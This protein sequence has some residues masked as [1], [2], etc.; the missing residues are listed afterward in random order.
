MLPQECI[1]NR[2]NVAAP[3][4]RSV[5]SQGSPSLELSWWHIFGEDTRQ[6]G[7]GGVG[8]D[9]E[10]EERMEEVYMCSNSFVN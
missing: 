9:E 8:G 3:P 7:S 4:L 10:K 1:K 2:S 6:E 5:G